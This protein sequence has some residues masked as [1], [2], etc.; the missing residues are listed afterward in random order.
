VAPTV[1]EFL[2]ADPRAVTLLAT[3]NR[4]TWQ[5]FVPIMKSPQVCSDKLALA[6]VEI[7]NFE[8]WCGRLFRAFNGL[9]P[10][11]GL[12]ADWAFRKWFTEGLARHVPTENLRGLQFRFENAM[13]DVEIDNLER[14]RELTIGIESSLRPDEEPRSAED[15][16]RKELFGRAVLLFGLRLGENGDRKGQLTQ[17]MRAEDLFEALQ[18]RQW[19]GQSRRLRAGALLCLRRIDEALELLESVWDIPRPEFI[20]QYAFRVTPRSDSITDLLNHAAQIIWWAPRLAP[21]W[22]E[23]V[24]SIG[25]KLEHAGCLAWHEKHSQM[26]I[27]VEI[28]SSSGPYVEDRFELRGPFV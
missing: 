11:D 15:N 4:L 14:I 10:D 21:Q 16:A 13:R 2:A 27:E 12:E 20:A 18:A 25:E 7:D 19:V 8:G 26:P 1:D 17:A 5:A 28:E 23:A 6:L 22:L 9:N 3:S 24:K